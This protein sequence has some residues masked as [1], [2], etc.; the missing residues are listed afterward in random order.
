MH[1][2]FMTIRLNSWLL[3]SGIL[4]LIL[5]IGA[6]LL[7]SAKEPEAT[8]KV[9]GDEKEA[10]VITAAALVK[11]KRMLDCTDGLIWFMVQAGQ[12]TD[13]GVYTNLQRTQLI[14]HPVNNPSDPMID[15]AEFEFDQESAIDWSDGCTPANDYNC[16]VGYEADP[17]NFEEVPGQGWL[18]KTGITPLC[19][20][21]RP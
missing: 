12:D 20:V 13:C 18:P 14:G 9:T 8:V 1:V 11:G 16:A 5:T 4:G 10:A 7:M 15:L 3:A 21:C 17:D 2:L 6:V 19:S